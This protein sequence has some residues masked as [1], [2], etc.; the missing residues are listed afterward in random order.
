MTDRLEIKRHP[1]GTRY[2]QPYLGT[3]AV[4]GRPLRPYHRF[5]DSMTDEECEAEAAR[6][7]EAIAPATGRRVSSRLDELLRI[8]V[9]DLAAQGAPANTVRSYSTLAG[10]AAPIGSMAVRDVKVADIDGLYTRLL[11]EGGRSGAG[12]SPDT[13]LALHWFLRGAFNWFALLGLVDVSP[14]IFARKPRHVRREAVAVMGED[15]SALNAAIAAE[16]ART[17]SDPASMRRHAAAFAAYLGLNM[18]IRAGEACAV[19]FSDVW[20]DRGLLHVSGTVVEPKGGAVRQEYT[21]GKRSR[22]IHITNADISAIAAQ[23][24]F[25]SDALGKAGGKMPLVTSDGGFMRPSEV[26]R[27]VGGLL[28]EAGL[29]EDV[30]FH[31]LRHTHASWLLAHGAD[32]KTVSERLGHADV[33]TTLQIYAHVMPGRDEAAAELFSKG[34]QEEG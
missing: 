24:A 9:E 6:W 4:T 21:K 5:P 26:S 19:R 3:N 30:A 25:L 1:D 20:A 34:M 12:L 13:V 17:D 33:A 32:V 28:R 23:R 16:L 15:L 27:T 31:S 11:K 10:Y 8:Y 18:G 7:L 22:N 2:V 14:V 29:P